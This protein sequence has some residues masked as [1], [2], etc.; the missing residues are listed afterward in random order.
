[1][2]NTLQVFIDK[3]DVD[4]VVESFARAST[5][6]ALLL[7]PSASRRTMLALAGTLV[8]LA[9]RVGA[10][11]TVD[12]LVPYLKQFY[13]NYDEFYALNAIDGSVTARKALSDGEWANV[14][15]H[16][17]LLHLYVP[18]RELV[19]GE[20]SNADLLDA[21]VGDAGGSGAFA[22]ATPTQWHATSSSSLTS[23]L[24][25]SSSAPAATVTRD[26]PAW[27]VPLLRSIDEEDAKCEPPALPRA[28]RDIV[29]V[30]QYDDVTFVDECACCCCCSVL[31]VTLCACAC[32][33]SDC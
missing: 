7:N 13:G 10:H 18:V 20:L 8:R 6:F 19:R 15:S 23:S 1:V 14:Y 3:F 26:V 4:D 21:L 9:R 31:R 12:V 30:A 33:R 11:V 24:S 29:L 17:M 25:A 16:D 5:L 27:Y 22:R 28:P 2:L 32:R